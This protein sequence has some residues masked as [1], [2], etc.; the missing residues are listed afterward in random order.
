VTFNRSEGK[1][2]GREVKNSHLNR[3]CVGLLVLFREYNAM[4]NRLLRM[5]SSKANGVYI[6]QQPVVLVLQFALL[7][8][9]A[10]ALLKRAMRSGSLCSAPLCIAAL[11]LR[12]RLERTPCCKWR[13]GGGV[14]GLPALAQGWNAVT[15]R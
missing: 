12:A 15:R 3:L 4:P 10:P 9:A 5:M 2:A 13:R 6:I 7:V 8:L 1:Q 14:H 11:L